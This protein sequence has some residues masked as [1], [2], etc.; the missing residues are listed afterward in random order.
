MFFMLD[1]VIYNLK[2]EIPAET[3]DFAKKILVKMVKI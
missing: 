1:Y 2:N 3:D